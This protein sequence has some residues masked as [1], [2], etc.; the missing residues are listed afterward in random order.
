MTL[1]DLAERTRFAIYTHFAAEGG[2]PARSDL[3]E[4]LA[5]TPE[6]YDAALAELAAARHVVLKDGEIEMAHPFATRSFGFSVMGP[7]TLWWGGCAWDSF[8]IPNLVPGAPEVLVATTC[9]ACGRPHA[10]VVTNSGPPPGDQVAHFLTP[11]HRIW[12]DAAH[13]CDNQLIFCSETHVEEWLER[14]GGDRGYVMSLETLWRLAAHWYDGR[15]G[16]PY[17]RREPIAAAE[18]FRSVG[19]R[20]PFW[21]LPDDDDHLPATAAGAPR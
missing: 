11:A 9:P 8:A 16:T 18:Y 7:E 10:W 5:I 14:T 1:T 6:E 20:G 13:A 17:I 15:L 4:E 3:A 21:G 19:L 12:P 2:L